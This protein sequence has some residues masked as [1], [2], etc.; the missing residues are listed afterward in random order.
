[1]PL[2]SSRL[3]YFPNS[4]ISLMARLAEQYQAI[5]LAQGV[6]DFDPPAE[7]LLAASRALSAG[8]NQYSSTWG[9]PRLRQALAQKQSAFTGLTIDPNE[10]V[11][12]TVGGT[13]ALLAALVAVTNPG[14]QVIVFSPHY[15]AY[16][17][18]SHL[19]AAEPVH[20]P[21][22]PPDFTFDPD[23]LRRAF[24]AGARVLVLC[25]PSNPTGKV[26][27]SEEL[28]SIAA[29]AQEYD[30][31]VLADEIYEHIV[32]SPHQHTYLSSLP[33]M[34]ERTIS[35]S[36]LSKTYAVT[37]WRVGWA[38]AAP[39][40]SA[41]LRK[42]H[43]FL[44]VCAPTPLQEAAVTALEF[45]MRYYQ[46]MQADYTRRRD[47]FLGYLREAGLHFI[48]PKGAYYVLV[49]ISPFGFKEDYE[50]CTWL[51]REI[52]VAVTPGSYFFHEPIKNFVRM[53]F[54]KSEDTLHAVGQRLLRLP[55]KI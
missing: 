1:M 33:G 19:L 52:G 40:V 13:E 39:A 5:N 9:S 49:D 22:R 10:H 41:G 42:V 25:N 36:S 8:Y 46:Q 37:G 17:V 51:V 7:L 28:H 15:E 43:D 48:E 3:N 23:E 32:Y 6:P 45:P 31:F 34:F 54:A 27:S 44:S 38:I 16:I 24:Q 35:C 21:L 47:I 14:D 30:A 20:I 50:F 4:A 2:P 29:L 53:N 18:D 26:F 11:T 55:E 12:I